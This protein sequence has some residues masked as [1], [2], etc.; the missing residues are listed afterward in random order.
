MD[1]VD[2]LESES[3]PCTRMIVLQVL[4][5]ICLLGELQYGKDDVV[6]ESPTVDLRDVNIIN[7]DENDG[8]NLKEGSVAQKS[9]SVRD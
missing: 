6:A 9:E 7:E 1:A 3:N 4:D 2:S 8:V 5:K